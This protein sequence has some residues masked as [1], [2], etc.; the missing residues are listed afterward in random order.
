MEKT[1]K[2]TFLNYVLRGICQGTIP[3]TIPLHV[4]TFMSLQ[5]FILNSQLIT[6]TPTKE[7]LY[8][9]FPEIITMCLEK[10]SCCLRS[11][12]LS[13]DQRRWQPTSRNSPGLL[14][15]CMDD[16]IPYFELALMFI[17]ICIHKSPCPK[18]RLPSL[19]LHSIDYL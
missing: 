17:C 12:V 5:D 6:Q 2:H 4:L 11:S 10:C 8:V 18:V 13:L 3:G 16:G 19:H 14:L 1:N 7:V 15:R 9:H